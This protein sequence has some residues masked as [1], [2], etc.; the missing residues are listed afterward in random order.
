[1]FQGKIL[2]LSQVIKSVLLLLVESLL[3][4]PFHLIEILMLITTIESVSC[5]RHLNIMCHLVT[6]DLFPCWCL[7]SPTTSWMGSTRSA[8]VWRARTT[9]VALRS[10]PRWSAAA[11]SAR[12][13]PSC[14]SSKWSW[15][16]PTSWASNPRETPPTWLQCYHIVIYVFISFWPNDMLW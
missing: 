8:A 11:I 3:L 15:P 14:P 13:L 6:H 5:D 4:A 7:S 9:S 1:M 2:P 10:T 16:S 12:S